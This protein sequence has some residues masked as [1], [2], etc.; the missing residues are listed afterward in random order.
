[1]QTQTTSTPLTTRNGVCVVDGYGIRI[2]VERG[3]LIVT[4][5]VGPDR[6][7]VRFNR[8]TAG[9]RRI[10][11]V[12]RSG[13]MSLAALQWLNDCGI[14]LVYLHP[15]GELLFTSAGFGLSDGRLRMKQA[16]SWG[17]NEGLAIAR[18]LLGK[19]LA[20]QADLAQQLPDGAAAA[21]KIDRLSATLDKAQSV[22]AL[23]AVEGA[24][25]ACYWAL[26]S[27]ILVPW[28]R[29]D[30]PKV[31]AHWR[32]VGS[33]TS[34]RSGGPRAAVSP[35]HAVINYLLG[36]VEAE[37]RLA[38]QAQGLDPAMP[39]LHAP[40]RARD[41]LV[42]DLQEAVRGEVDKFVLDL[43]ATQV[44]RAADFHEDR[45]GV[46]RVLAP[47][48]HRLAETAPMWAQHLGPVV[49]NVAKAFAAGPGVPVDDL[50]TKLTQ[51]NRSAGR[52]GVRR[53]PAQVAWKKVPRL[54][55]Q[56]CRGCGNE[57]GPNQRWCN[58]CR[59][60]VKLQAGRHGLAA[61]RS[62]RASLHQH[63]LDPATSPASR[64][65]QKEARLRRRSEEVAWDNDH[66]QRS[67]QEVFRQTVLPAIAGVP[68]RR[69][70]NATGLSVGYCGLIR[71]GLRV[72]HIRWWEAL[73]CAAAVNESRSS[74]APGSLSTD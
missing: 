6:R 25:G 49:E 16:R 50:P 12:A 17:T 35:V 20:A 40:L 31:P 9:I 10:V 74:E 22:E 36:I 61:A 5:G 43:L 44:F 64:A 54:P 21:A 45:R 69:L 30:V 33:R 15:S 68:I 14:A 41:G 38:C 19:K 53:H 70:A 58:V 67:D 72:P 73:A 3:H 48:T 18:F 42:L 51:A 39:V 66:L 34:I 24:A 52:D 60:E 47:L 27:T 65:K 57:I 71:R 32:V 26:W 7:A 37:A 13:V 63:G 56:T 2:H 55:S 29:A 11:L 28:V 4:D 62:L 46:V 1:M 8:A 23:M 59:P